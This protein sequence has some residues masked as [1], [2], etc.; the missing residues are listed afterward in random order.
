MS[1]DQPPP[2]PEPATIDTLLRYKV[3]PSSV[4]TDLLYALRN[5]A[6]LIVDALRPEIAKAQAFVDHL[7][8]VYDLSEKAVDIFDASKYS[9]RD[10]GQAFIPADSGLIRPD[11]ENGGL[12]PSGTGNASSERVSVTSQAAAA[13]EAFTGADLRAVLSLRE[14]LHDGGVISGCP[15]CPDVWESE[16]TCEHAQAITDH[17]RAVAFR[18]LRGA[19]ARAEQQLGRVSGSGV[20]VGHRA[21]Q[22][23]DSEAERVAAGEDW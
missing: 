18:A 6:F 12:N 5:E 4:I 20:D 1:T 22:W 17:D 13:P 8:Q 19:A 16:P 10:F 7:E 23:L 21:S 2:R 9:D 11:R 15:W 14:L 3:K